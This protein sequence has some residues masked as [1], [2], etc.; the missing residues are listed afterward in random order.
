[1]SVPC[2]SV[3]PISVGLDI[4]ATKVHGVAVDADGAILAEHREPT[5]LGSDGVLRTAA[6]VFE[7]LGAAGPA[8]PVG[9]GVPGLVDPDRGT[10]KYAVNLGLNGD[11]VP[12]GE[13]LADRLGTSVM[14][15]NDVNAAT[16]GAHLIAAADDVAYISLGTGLAAGMVLGGVLRRGTH[17]AAGEIGHLPVDPNGPPCSCG[18]RGCLELVASGSALAAAWPSPDRPPAQAL[19]A[20]AAAGD[21][22]AVAIRDRFTAGVA[23]AVRVI[24]L[25]VD[26]RAI[27]IGGG[28]A[29]LGEPLRVAVAAALARQAEG[30]PFL[31]SL[32]LPG[33]LQV[34]PAGIPIAALGAALLGRKW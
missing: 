22:R 31:A 12:L 3:E 17:G 32:D 25:A 33:R 13:M 24:A 30:S 34:V 14:V 26:P 18:Q 1:M 8:G 28:V 16:L 9:V 10:V 6:T 7:A 15:E 21:T 11:W 29:A 20:A 23:D 2:G 19:F 27:V 5:Q 4:G